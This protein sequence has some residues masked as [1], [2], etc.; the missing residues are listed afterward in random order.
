MT[1]PNTES[2]ES[3]FYHNLVEQSS[4]MGVYIIQHGRFAYV[5]PALAASFGYSVAE[6]LALETVLT[7]IHPEDQPLVLENLQRR[8]AG[9]IQTAQ[10]DFRGLCKDGTIIQLEV[11]GATI[12]YQGEVAVIGTLIDITQRKQ[13][14]ETLRQVQSQNDILLAME[15]SRLITE[16]QHAES[17]LQER[18]NELNALQRFLTREAWQAYQ[19]N[20]ATSSYLFDPTQGWAE[21]TPPIEEM[22]QTQAL[23]VRGE[24]IGLLGLY[25]EGGASLSAEERE[26][27]ETISQQV[28]EAV[29]N[30]R[31][32]EQTRK[33]AVELA[34]VAQVSIMASSVLEV[35]KLLQTVVNLT[36]I[37]FHL[38]HV[39]IYLL[40]QATQ[41]LELAA[42]AGEIGQQTMKL[43]WRIPLDRTNS[44]MAQAA[45]TQS[46]VLVNDVRA[47]TSFLPNPFLPEVRAIL[48]VP[49]VAGDKMLGVLGVL[50]SQ[51]NAFT[52]ED[53]QI[54]GVLAAQV[55]VAIQNAR[56]Y[57]ETRQ[58]A[59]QLE[60]QA[61]RLGLLNELGAE[62]TRARTLEQIFKVMSL[63]IN[64]IMLSTRATILLLNETGDTFSYIG[65][66][67][68]R[69]QVTDYLSVNQTVAG[70]VVRTNT[71]MIVT[72]T[73]EITFPGVELLV[74]EGLRSGILVPLVAGGK[75]IGTL[76]IWHKQ[77]NQYNSLDEKLMQQIA[78]LL[79]TTVEN[80]RLFEEAKKRANY[81]EKLAQ[82][83][84]ALA[85]AVTEEDIL[86]AIALATPPEAKPIIFLNYVEVN[87]LGQP[88]SI[89]IL[90]VKNSESLMDSRLISQVH[91]VDDLFNPPI[92]VQKSDQL[93][94]IADLKQGISARES[95]H[96]IGDKM[97]VESV[98]ILPLF[99]GGRWQALIVFA[100]TQ[101]HDLS[102]EERFIF[103]KLLEPVGA[104]VA[105]RRAYVAQ[106]AAL[107]ETEALYAGS[108]RIVRASN[109]TEILQ[110]LVESTALAQLDTV[111][112]LLFDQPFEQ[113]S[114]QFIKAVAVWYQPS[115]PELLKIGTQIP[116]ADFP[117]IYQ[118]RRD[119]PLIF[120]D[121]RT[122]QQFES[123]SFQT[124]VEQLNVYGMLFF[125]LIAG[126]QWIGFTSGATTYR[127]LPVSNLEIRQISNL[128]DQVAAVIQNQL[129]LDRMQRT[130]A[131]TQRLYEAGRRLNSNDLQTAMAAVFEAQPILAVNRG[132][133][134]LIDWVRPGEA[135][136]VV[137][138]A[139][140]HSGVGALP[141][142]VGQRYP[143]R[144]LENL[145]IFI[146]PELIM[147]EDAQHD[148][149]LTPLALQVLIQQ[150]IASVAI[151][152]L[153][154]GR[155]Q[156]GTL[157]LETEEIHHFTAEELE[158]YL[159]L[160]GP[161]ALVVDRNSLLNEAEARAER[162]K[163]VR[164]ITNK[165]R[166]TVGREA[167]LN[168]AREEI[169]QLL[170]ATPVVTELG[171]R[172]Q[173]LNRL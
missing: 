78:S 74:A 113:T 134:L 120:R 9:E 158:P 75:V 171:T 127:P 50:S 85:L 152:P 45:S 98:A 71:L 146:N 121:L 138:A 118:M 84:A 95:A 107:A 69:P 20:A 139:N 82:V 37:R 56:L 93:I 108:D 133:M 64:D 61:H 70:E 52:T 125:P 105:S 136:G 22:A 172:E 32:L 167:I 21:L 25:D 31:L 39:H 163:Q 11:S 142:S 48:A 30:A 156:L 23:M 144:Y 36:K 145:F 99:I 112:I 115:Q 40:N 51:I 34:A 123:P 129:L 42:G 19:I 173:L 68:V 53:V 162:E 90:S 86:T 26:L 29:D 57:Q 137:V 76:N 7:V 2:I 168:T 43:G 109:P 10:Y 59:A 131:L 66:H 164:E 83:E 103:T 15:N 102:E 116:F 140:W 154:V 87:E 160:T 58:A 119:E 12:T 89:T 24:S 72:D 91:L 106:K 38:Y 44:V 3:I 28:A 5:N 49:I 60:Q 65:L 73:R 6:C 150:N 62:L 67:G 159:A 148:S 41:E 17:E 77:A 149:Q 135:V 33:R 80:Q 147:F 104:I 46:G 143:T 97:G 96:L 122:Q 13:T 35:D 47:S 169:G 126:G 4:L 117:A 8:L 1:P 110:V 170:Q 128:T 81:L 166:Q 79:A 165:I 16:R 157:L 18:L 153:T 88:I 54:H 124:A 111:A 92:W 114:P 141:T 132:V 100:W 27:L 94:F 14:E 161:L 151:L 130:L 155:R 101:P 55:A 63:K